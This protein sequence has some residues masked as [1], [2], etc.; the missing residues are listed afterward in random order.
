MST[1]SDLMGLGMPAALANRLG[2]TPAVI[3]CAGTT[4]AAATTIQTHLSILSTGTSTTGAIL[5]SSAS[6]GG[7]F[8]AAC[9]AA[10]TAVVYCPVSGTLNGT[11]NAGLSVAQNKTAIFYRLTGSGDDWVSVL[12]A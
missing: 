4:Q 1:V 2:L 12:T 3:T 11:T 5:P 9:T 10:T 7:V 6:L 8:V